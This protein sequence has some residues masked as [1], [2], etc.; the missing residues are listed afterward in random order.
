MS[1]R[2][3][4][5]GILSWMMFDWANQPFQTLIVTFVFAPYFASQV[6]GDPVVGQTLWGT[7]ATI[8]GVTVALLAPVL[9]AVADRTGARKPW[10]LLFSVPYVLGCAGLWLAVPGMDPVWPV[11]FCFVLAFAGSELTLVFNNSM[12]PALG[13]RSEIGRISGSGWAVGYAGGLVALTLMLTMVVPSPGSGTTVIGLIP[14]FGLD[15]AVGEPARLSGPFS[16]LWYLVFALPMF[17]FTPDRPRIVAERNP[18]SKGL[19]DLRSTFRQVRRRR[20]LFTYLFA[21]MLYR[22]ALAALFA[23]GGIYASGILGWGLFELGIFGIIAAG[24]G[25][26]GAWIGGKA[27]RAYGPRPVIKSA[28]WL[29]IAVCVTVLLTNRNTVFMVPIPEASRAPDVIF[30]IAGGL[31]GAAAGT[32]QA[33]SRTM[34]IHQAEGSMQA[35]QAFGLYA[36]SGKATAFIGPALITLATLLSGSQQIGVSPVILLFLAGLIL[37]AWVDTGHEQQMGITK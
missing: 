26:I 23:F 30:L 13:D 32:L 19:A 20:S 4:R 28:I 15:A 1:I 14:V 36:L 31:L 6:I 24:T 12:L 9:G 3:N 33:A 21:S 37:L 22:D 8:G 18:V 25:A 29:L 2:T 27:D 7:A 10:I 34:L 16:A 35:A 17:F 11:L 5:R